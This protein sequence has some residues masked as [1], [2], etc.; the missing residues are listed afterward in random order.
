[1]VQFETYCLL[2]FNSPCLLIQRKIRTLDTK[3]S[4]LNHVSPKSLYLVTF[5]LFESFCF[6]FFRWSSFLVYFSIFHGFLVKFESLRFLRF[7]SR[8]LA[9]GLLKN[10]MPL[11]FVLLCSVF[12]VFELFQNSR[13]L[14]TS[15][16]R[17]SLEITAKVK[18]NCGLSGFEETNRMNQ[19]CTFIFIKNDFCDLNSARW[20]F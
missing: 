1:M 14:A 10:C 11:I 7:L 19:W 9:S 17:I 5:T 12:S 16:C 20:R 15:H 4:F 13:F 18:S 6:C 2:P 8:M 3:R